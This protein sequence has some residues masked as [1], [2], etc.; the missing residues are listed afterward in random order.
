MNH[1]QF[2]RNIANYYR[3]KVIVFINGQL[4]SLP[5]FIGDKYKRY[6]G[7][8][9]SNNIWNPNSAL[10]L[11]FSYTTLSELSSRV[12]ANGYIDIT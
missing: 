1:T 8:S 11:D 6:A 12:Y 3:K 7:G 9:A 4:S 2:I 10:D 5:L